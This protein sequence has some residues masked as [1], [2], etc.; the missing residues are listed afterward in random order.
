MLQ[1]SE[2]INNCQN[3]NQTLPSTFCS[4]N[5]SVHELLG[6]I[7]CFVPFENAEF[8]HSKDENVRNAW[9]IV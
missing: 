9:K 8:A 3:S 6:L 4:I 7:L 2:C 1:Q 5:F